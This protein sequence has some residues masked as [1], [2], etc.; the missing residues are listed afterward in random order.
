[1]FV[2]KLRAIC[3]QPAVNR[4]IPIYRSSVPR[5][6]GNQ[7][8]VLATT[9]TVVILGALNISAVRAESLAAPLGKSFLLAQSTPVGQSDRAGRPPR[10]AI[11]ACANVDPQS[12]CSFNGRSGETVQGKCM[13]TKADVPLACVPANPPKNG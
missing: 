4:K 13:S 12:L 3:A 10:E 1:M 11:E 8:I 9:F 6:Q 2:E 7:K 5:T